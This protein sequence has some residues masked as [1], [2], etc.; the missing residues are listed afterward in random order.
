[1]THADKVSQ[2]YILNADELR[3]FYF[4]A[5]CRA[6]L[7]PFSMA[8][9]AFVLCVFPIYLIK[10]GTDPV[11][12]IYV[13]IW[14]VGFGVFSFLL[15]PLWLSF[16][17]WKNYKKTPANASPR[18]ATATPK[19]LIFDNAEEHTELGWSAITDMRRSANLL[20][21]YGNRQCAFMVPVRAFS[22]AGEAEA[23]I[24]AARHFKAQHTSQKAIPLA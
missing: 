20:M 9:Y 17:N 3:E 11:G 19:G 6:A 12:W 1:M 14:F 15:A 23:F 21:F 13:L 8:L 2:P 10:P 5:Y 16:V 24:E 22:E 18:T 7:A 4:R